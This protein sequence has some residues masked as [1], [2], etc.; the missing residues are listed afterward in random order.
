MRSYPYPLTYYFMSTFLFS[1]FVPLTMIAPADGADCP[2]KP[3]QDMHCT[4][5]SPYRSNVETLTAGLNDLPFHLELPLLWTMQDTRK[6]YYFLFDSGQHGLVRLSKVPVT[7]KDLALPE[8]KAELAVFCRDLDCWIYG[9]SLQGAY[10]AHIEDRGGE[11]AMEAKH[12]AQALRL[13][14]SAALD[15]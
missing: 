10:L 5:V 1:L 2:P 7:T 9:K 15:L 4:Y 13:I 14:K 12:K 3:P 6:A 11:G 8:S